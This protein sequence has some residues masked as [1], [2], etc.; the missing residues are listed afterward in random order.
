MGNFALTMKGFI[1]C[2]V[3]IRISDPSL[4]H[5]F[6]FLTDLYRKIMIL[7]LIST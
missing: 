4:Y 5:L 2:S 3:L 6:C 7:H 1:H